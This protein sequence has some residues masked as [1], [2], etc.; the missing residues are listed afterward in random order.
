MSSKLTRVRRGTTKYVDVT[1]CKKL[2]HY[3][4]RYVPFEQ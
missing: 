2:W 3:S 1:R 4:T